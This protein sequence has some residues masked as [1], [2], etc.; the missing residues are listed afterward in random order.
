[1]CIISNK[2]N[3]LSKFNLKVLGFN[4]QNFQ[5]P[6]KP[7]NRV[8]TVVTWFHGETILKAAEQSEQERKSIENSYKF[9]I[10]S[11]MGFLCIWKATWNLS[12]KN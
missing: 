11:W 2:M 6:S 8:G 3:N 4:S 10:Q 12:F 1:M 9:P 7:L 5:V